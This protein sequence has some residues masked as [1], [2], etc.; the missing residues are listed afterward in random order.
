M[1]SSFL[2]TF[3]T[4]YSIVA[5]ALTFCETVQSLMIESRKQF[6]LDSC[7]TSS[8]SLLSFVL[9]GSDTTSSPAQMYPALSTTDIIISAFEKTTNTKIRARATATMQTTPFVYSESWTGTA[10]HLMSIEEAAKKTSTVLVPSS[11]VPGISS[12]SSGAGEADL[13]V[14]EMGRWPDSVL[15]T[16][17]SPVDPKWFGTEE[18]KRVC[19]LL[20][21]TSQKANAVGLAAQQCG[22]DARIVYLEY[23]DD[24]Y[25]NAQLL[26]IP[27]K[28]KQHKKNSSSSS[29]IMI[30]PKIIRRSPEADMK[31]WQENCLVL[32]PTFVATVLR[33][34]SV[35]VEYHDGNDDQCNLCTVRLHGE[36]ARA[37][38][39]ELDHDRGIL[40]LDHVDLED[41][42]NDQM[43]YFERQDHEIRMRIAYSREVAVPTVN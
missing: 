27:R 18:L 19:R 6:L 17:A 15:R 25:K 2:Y 21:N 4:F 36:L 3:W 30:N 34:D 13:E 1:V 33:D 35:D 41:M 32:P 14:W 29:I 43:R 16:P 39:H 11:K 8:S 20:Q 22:V 31:V 23:D 10:L 28:R 5:Y 7:V 9:G 24:N 37:A 40:T 38:Q 12:L 42:E 26:P